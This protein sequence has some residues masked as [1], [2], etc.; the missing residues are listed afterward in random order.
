[1]TAVNSPASPQP[2]DTANQCNVE[3]KPNH[4]PAHE[5]IQNVVYSIL[6]FSYGTY[7]VWIND[8]YIPAKKSRKGIHLHDV[9]AWI[10]YGAMICA[11]LVM[12]SV[13]ADH[14]DRRNNER[15]YKLFFNVFKY[16]GW[17]FFALAFSTSIVH[18]DGTFNQLMKLAF[19]FAGFVIF[20]FWFIHLAAKKDKEDKNQIEKWRG[21]ELEELKN[22]SIK[23]N[24]KQP[25][26][27]GDD[28]ET[29]QHKEYENRVENTLYGFEVKRILRSKS[30]EYFHWIWSS[31]NPHYL[32]HI[33]QVNAKIILKKKYIAP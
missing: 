26:F 31:D 6:L 14:Y 7:G 22:L 27:N 24:Q 21:E 32:K 5:R 11:C 3:Y 2:I 16:S 30:G 25:L 13:V 8:L 18:Y 15:N 9:P 10:M 12:I 29:M 17:C 23:S 20:I 4:I 33:T 19:V 28:F 1:M